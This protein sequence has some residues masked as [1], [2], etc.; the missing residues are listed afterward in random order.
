MGLPSILN[1]TDVMKFRDDGVF[2]GHKTKTQALYTLPSYVARG[3]DAFSDIEAFQY[4][5]F[6]TKSPFENA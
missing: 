1:L 5:K 6:L 3:E 4:A 2:A